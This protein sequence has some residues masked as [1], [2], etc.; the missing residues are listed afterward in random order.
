M[1]QSFFIYFSCHYWLFGEVQVW[2]ETQVNRSI[3]RKY[4]FGWTLKE[5]EVV[6]DGVAARIKKIKWTEAESTGGPA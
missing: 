6:T 3:W 4:A 2:G 1:S 5:G